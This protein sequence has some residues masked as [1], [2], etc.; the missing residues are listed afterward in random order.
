MNGGSESIFGESR[1][2][3]GVLYVGLGGQVVRLWID[4]HEELAEW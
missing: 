4:D 1:W 2:L 3:K